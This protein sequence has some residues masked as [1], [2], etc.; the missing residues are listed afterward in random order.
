MSNIHPSENSYVMDPESA[1]EMARLLDLDIIVNKQMGAL[2][3]ADIDLGRV[4]DVL[5]IACGPGG[6]AMEVAFEHP[7]KHVV[8]IDISRAML[9]YA[10]AQAK[11]QDLQNV[12]FR[13][14]DATSKLQF[15]EASFDLINARFI[16][17]FM[18]KEAWPELIKE[19]MRIL[20]PGG[21]VRF[22]DTDRG[23][24][25]TNSAALE[26]FN[27]FASKAFVRT[28]RSFCEEENA[29]HFGL[30]PMLGAL[31]AEAGCENIREIPHMLNYSAGEPAHF[32]L[33]HNCEVG[34]ALLAPFFKKTGVASQEE[35]EQLYQQMLREIR[36]DDFRGIW[37]F[38]SAYG[39]KPL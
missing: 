12:E 7:D 3:P 31:L 37:Y 2:F 38:M 17:G 23:F 1:M 13:F 4:H 18:W 8:G 15:P 30:T 9:E 16:V 19:C 32:A 36:R 39:E 5:D 11:V 35:H 28:G 29:N 24:S 6:W 20:R 21:I 14:M 26:K 33:A 25:P 22:T 34:I 10:T 27:I